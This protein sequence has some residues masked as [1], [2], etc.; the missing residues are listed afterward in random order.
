M[1]YS[2]IVSSAEVY[3]TTVNS[4]SINSVNFEYII[5]RCRVC[6]HAHSQEG[7]KGCYDT[8]GNSVAFVISCRCKEHVPEDNLEYLEYLLKKKEII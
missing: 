6:K 7:G 1:N 3:T 4:S 8:V 5:K 2:N